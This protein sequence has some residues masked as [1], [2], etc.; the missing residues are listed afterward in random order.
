[1]RL[2]AREA[3]GGGGELSLV[4]FGALVQHSLLQKPIVLYCQISAGGYRCLSSAISSYRARVLTAGTHR[5]AHE[6]QRSSAAPASKRYLPTS[7]HG[8]PVIVSTVRLSSS[9][10]IQDNKKLQAPHFI[11]AIRFFGEL[12]CKTREICTAVTVKKRGAIARPSSARFHVR[13]GG[14]S[15][16][17]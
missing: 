6:D 12:G 7:A 11:L 17:V 13:E 15:R 8:L 5:T 4:Y 9:L 10:Q 16:Q 1:M 14:S 2:S 3:F